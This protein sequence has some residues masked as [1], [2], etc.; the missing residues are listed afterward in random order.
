MLKNVK[1]QRN[2]VIRQHLTLRGQMKFRVRDRK[3]RL[4]TTF[5]N[6]NYNSTKAIGA[7]HKFQGQIKTIG[8][9]INCLAFLISKCN[10]DKVPEMQFSI[11]TRKRHKHAGQI[12]NCATH[13]IGES[14]C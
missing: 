9:F 1:Q 11:V 12:I 10:G 14:R 4:M 2:D 8:Q 3:L 13:V 6:Y 5:A 7:I